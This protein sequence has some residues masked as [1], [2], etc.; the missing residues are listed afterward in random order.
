MTKRVITFTLPN[1]PEIKI[2]VEPP[3][4]GITICGPDDK[5]RKVLTKPA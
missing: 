5:T 1:N 3:P 4:H 2:K